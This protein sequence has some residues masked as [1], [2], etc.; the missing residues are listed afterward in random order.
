MEGRGR[1]MVLTVAALRTELLYAPRPRAALGVGKKAA[2]HLV[3]ILKRKRPAGVLVVGF[4]GGL[5][6]ALPPGTFVLA[7]QLVED[8]GQRSA[9]RVL[10]DGEFLG[11]AKEKLPEARVGTLVTLD[12]PVGP[13]EKACL[14]IDALGVDLESAHLALELSKRGIPFLVLRIVLDALWEEPPFGARRALWARRAIACARQLDRAAQALF[15]TLE[16]T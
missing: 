16:A 1:G 9:L 14:G 2:P 3:E 8:P 7:D 12:R 15:P 5:H 4:C 13:A 10:V 11:K 6:A